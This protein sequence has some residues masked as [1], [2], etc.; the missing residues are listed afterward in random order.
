MEQ[1]NVEI[2]NNRV[3]ECYDTGFTNQGVGRNY[4]EANISYHQ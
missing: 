2:S 4:T 1:A 3:W